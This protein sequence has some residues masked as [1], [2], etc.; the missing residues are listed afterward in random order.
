MIFLCNGCRSKT[1]FRLKLK[2]IYR[3]DWCISL[4]ISYFQ[5][6]TTNYIC[7]YVRI[8]WNWLLF[9]LFPD[10]IIVILAICHCWWDF[11]FGGGKRGGK[12]CSQIWIII[13]I[14]SSFTIWLWGCYKQ[15]KANSTL[16]LLIGAFWILLEGGGQ[17]SQFKV[18]Y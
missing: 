5:I 14:V 2:L 10:T 6:S 17:K 12:V 8:C 13:K 1:A 7:L 4:K 16:T 11:F 9:C 3:L 15:E 18:L